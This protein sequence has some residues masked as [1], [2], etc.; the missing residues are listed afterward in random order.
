MNKIE[1]IV[2]IIIAIVGCVAGLWGA[3]TAHDA[4]KFKQPF[5][6]HDEI[7]KSFTSQISSA[8]KR[9]DKTEVIRVRLSYEKFEESWRTARQIAKITAPFEN[10]ATYQLSP[11]QSN[12]LTKLLA[13]T[14]TE[15]NAL[16]LSTKTLG[17]AYLAL[18]NYQKAA[19]QLSVVSSETEDSNTLALKAAAFSGLASSTIDPTTKSRYEVT[20][21]ESF[22]AAFK[23]SSGR[24]NE[25]YAFA[26]ANPNLKT[27]LNEKGIKLTSPSSQR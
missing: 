3:Y 11:D 16:P 6:E 25:L 17:A 10:L 27:I 21:A 2:T 4:S 12:N 9:N 23:E 24:T 5:D 15:P 8:E 13:T 26:E 14:S 19:E 20:A 7:S 18:G 22:R 1:K